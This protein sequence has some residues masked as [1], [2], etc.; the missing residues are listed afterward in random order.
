VRHGVR[1][2]TLPQNLLELQ[3]LHFGHGG[4]IDE[5]FMLK[6]P[7]RRHRL[8]TTSAETQAAA[9]HWMSLRAISAEAPPEG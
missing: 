9:A 5:V 2:P 4:A 7:P 1:S 6:A 3:P 8:P